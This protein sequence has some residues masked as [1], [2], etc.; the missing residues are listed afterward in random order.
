MAAAN[1]SFSAQIDEWVAKTK[2]RSTAV[3]RDSSQSVSDAMTDNL[4]GVL[5][6]VQTGFLRASQQASLEAMPQIEAKGYPDPGASYQFD[7]GEI[8]LVIANAQL[9]DT[10][11]LGFTAAY[12]P[13]VEYGTS[14]MA[15]RGFVRLAA[16]QW[17]GVVTRSAAAAKSRVGS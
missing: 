5:V 9:G 2:E 14:K 3:F 8:A 12:G 10:I 1:L 7:A 11:Y 6:N 4:S 15:G 17:D 16:I 13:F